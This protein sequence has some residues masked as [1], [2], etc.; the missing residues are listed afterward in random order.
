ME[1][2]EPVLH[3]GGP[4][5]CREDSNPADILV[6]RRHEK[7]GFAAPFTW[8]G[9]KRDI[10]GIGQNEIQ[11]HK[12]VV[13]NDQ[14]VGLRR[15]KLRVARCDALLKILGMV[16]GPAAK[17]LVFRLLASPSLAL[18]GSQFA[19]PSRTFY[20][21]EHLPPIGV[22]N[23]V[24]P[25]FPTQSQRSPLQDIEAAALQEVRYPQFIEGFVPLGVFGA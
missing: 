22:A 19:L 8:T 17:T 13:G 14:E 10:S 6:F 12:E 5:L 21:Y 18:I 23:E 15:R 24:F 2:S 16:Y 7:P 1:Y 20:F 3:S 4:A 9:I 11:R 25:N